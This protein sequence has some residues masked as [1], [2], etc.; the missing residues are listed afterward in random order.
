MEIWFIVVNCKLSN[1]FT[2]HQLISSRKNIT[3]QVFTIVSAGQLQNIF[4]E[5]P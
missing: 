5:F 3:K 1:L 2:D 4:T